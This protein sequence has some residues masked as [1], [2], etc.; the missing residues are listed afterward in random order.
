M[1]KSPAWSQT[2]PSTCLLIHLYTLMHQP[3][4]HRRGQGTGTR[5]GM[6]DQW[7]EQDEEWRPTHYDLLTIPNHRHFLEYTQPLCFDDKPDYSYLRKL[8]RDL[9][10]QEGCQYDCVFDWRML[11][12]LTSRAS[13]LREGSASVVSWVVLW[14]AGSARRTCNSGHCTDLPWSHQRKSIR[15]ANKWQ[16]R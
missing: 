10:N 14:S 13:R 9:F 8:F 6:D 7:W 11:A 12:A 5:N 16:T 15:D 2:K 3:Q 1:F 4:R